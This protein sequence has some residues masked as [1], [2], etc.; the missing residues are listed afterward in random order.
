MQMRQLNL[1]L[2]STAV[3]RRNP[4]DDNKRRAILLEGEQRALSNRRHIC[5][6]AQRKVDAIGLPGIG[7]IGSRVFF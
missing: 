1:W 2:A 5:A 3:P 6:L 7:S 4:H